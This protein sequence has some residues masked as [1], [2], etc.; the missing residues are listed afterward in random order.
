[1]N[2][3]TSSRSLLSAVELTLELSLVALGAG[4]IW[5]FREVNP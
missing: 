1:M 3:A 5:K 2:A 4:I